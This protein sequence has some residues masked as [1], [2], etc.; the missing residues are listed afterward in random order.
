ML[1]VYKC[2]TMQKCHILNNVFD[3]E[4]VFVIGYY[5]CKI[6]HKCIPMNWF[7]DGDDDCGMGEDELPNCSELISLNN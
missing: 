7:C 6:T 4:I 2:L 5:E 3:L 1:L